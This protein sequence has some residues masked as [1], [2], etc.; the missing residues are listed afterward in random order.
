MGN[1]IRKDEDHCSYEKSP[2]WGDIEVIKDKKLPALQFLIKFIANK[3]DPKDEKSIE[4]WQ[5]IKK[6]DP[7]YSFMIIPTEVRMNDDNDLMGTFAKDF[8][9]LKFENFDYSLRN[10]S[11]EAAIS[12]PFIAEIT[13]LTLLAITAQM[14]SFCEENDIRHFNIQ[15]ESYILKAD[16]FWCL[17]PPFCKT[18]NLTI[19]S[20]LY[21]SGK[22]EKYKL[23]EDTEFLIPQSTKKYNKSVSVK[24]D[25]YSAGLTLIHSVYKFKT[26]DRKLDQQT[27]DKQI[28]YL[29]SYYSSSLVDILTKM[30]RVDEAERIGPKELKQELATHS[31]VV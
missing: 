31:V 7:Y 2:I 27:I 3:K 4:Y 16:G 22:R 10:Y 28:G 30:T 8:V 17:L 13:L 14:L 21:N 20:K 11:Q 25:I 12:N 15:P 5:L 26:T 29:K 19:V 23:K 1:S 9:R 6:T 24:S 18:K